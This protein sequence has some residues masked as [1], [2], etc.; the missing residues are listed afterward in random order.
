MPTAPPGGLQL[1]GL[2]GPQ[3]DRRGRVYVA[4]E[5]GAWR[6]AMMGGRWPT[7]GTRAPLCFGSTCMNPGVWGASQG[8]VFC[9]FLSI[10][11]PHHISDV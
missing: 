10:S 9:Q 7:L 4:G 11:W 8:D 1:K 6:L 3:V 5:A 2:E